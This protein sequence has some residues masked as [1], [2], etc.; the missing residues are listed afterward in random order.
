M[1]YADPQKQREY[2]RQYR[3]ANREAARERNRRWSAENRSKISEKGRRWRQRQRDLER[4][5]LLPPERLRKLRASRRRA[6]ARVKQWQH[7]NYGRR[8][9]YS[10]QWEAK[11]GRRHGR[12]LHRPAWADKGKI[13][14]I[15]AESKRLTRETGRPH[16]VDHVVPLNNKLVSGL[17]VEFNL[18]VAKARANMVKGN[19]FWPDMP[20]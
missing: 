4:D 9:L 13:A 2:H 3:E 5:G 16:H 14:A 19:R 12:G 10:L 15:Y 20:R 17:H 11:H 1:P 7:E 8:R 18:V 6:V